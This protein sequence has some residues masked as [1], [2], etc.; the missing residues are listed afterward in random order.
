MTNFFRRIKSFFYIL[1]ISLENISCETLAVWLASAKK[2]LLIDCR[3]F[4]SFTT[5]RVRGAHSMRCNSIKMRRCKGKKIKILQNLGKI[6]EK[7]QNIEI[8]KMKVV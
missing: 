8:P 4:L 3:A 7:F 2:V 1:L 6:S 5:R